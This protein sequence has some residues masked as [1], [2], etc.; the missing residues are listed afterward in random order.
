MVRLA[1]SNIGVQ[2]SIKAGSK[3][4][5]FSSRVTLSS[6]SPFAKTKSF[7]SSLSLPLN[8]LHYG[9]FGPFAPRT[10]RLYDDEKRSTKFL[11]EFCEERML[12]PVLVMCRIHAESERGKIDIRRYSLRRDD[13]Y[14]NRYRDG[15]LI[16][17][18]LSRIIL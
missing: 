14:E 18:T 1:C 6:S 17:Q 5:L 12:S 16:Y 7:P 2:I 4:S 13:D 8:T 9:T 3:A 11:L 10:R 15:G